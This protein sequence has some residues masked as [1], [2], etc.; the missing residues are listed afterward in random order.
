MIGIL[1]EGISDII[2][3]ELE[4]SDLV[5][6]E[7]VQDFIKD[8]FSNSLVIDRD[9]LAKI[10][11]ESIA[12]IKVALKGIVDSRPKE[13]PFTPPQRPPV[14]NKFRDDRGQP[15]AYKNNKFKKKP[16]GKN[17]KFKKFDFKKKKNGYHDK[18]K[19]WNSFEK[20]PERD[21]EKNKPDTPV[22]IFL[23]SKKPQD[24]MQEL[25]FL[26]YYL[27]QVDGILE[28]NV[29]DFHNIYKRANLRV[30][31]VFD[32]L[33]R[34]L[35]KSD[36]LKIAENKKDGYTAWKITDKVLKEINQ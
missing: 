21:H 25:K 13:T 12:E 36:F 2:Q 15:K 26:A 24:K 5:K 18:K 27:D 23:K 16:K 9:E 33:V 20:R 34:F 7:D 19:K 35:V 32:T 6:K 22:S 8:N 31:P 29:R 28:Y 17:N 4:K 14:E 10:V 30:P 3:Q 1:P 11:A